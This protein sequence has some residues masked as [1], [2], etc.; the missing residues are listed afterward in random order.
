MNWVF[1]LRVKLLLP[2]L[3]G[4]IAL[5]VGLHF[6]LLPLL[7][8][9]ERQEFELHQYQL[10]HAVEP[11]AVHHLLSAGQDGLHTAMEEQKALYPEE[12]CGLSLFD[13]ND[14]KLYPPDLLKEECSGEH[15]IE[16]QQPVDLDGQSLGRLTLSV[17]WSHQ[18]EKLESELFQLESVILVL[19]L[20]VAVAGFV[21]QNFLIRLPLIRLQRAADKLSA[22]NFWSPLPRAGQDEMG[23]LTKAFERMRLEL[24]QT[25]ADIQDA[26][27]TSQ[28]NEARHLAVINTMADGLITVDDRGIVEGFNPAAEHI[29]GYT[30]DEVL[31]RNVAMLLPQPDAGDH[32]DFIAR[33]RE[34]AESNSSVHVRE[35]TGQHKNGDR[36]NLEVN[37]KE[38]KLS[39]GKIFSV[40]LRD[41]SE[42]RADEEALR[43]AASAFEVQ[44]GIVITDKGAR[45]LRVNRAFSKITGYREDEVVGK[46]PRLLQSGTHNRAF[47]K[48]FWKTL[49]DSGEWSGELLNQ[50]K[51]GEH[52]PQRTRISA[53]KN[54]QGEVTHYV[55][56]F[57]DVTERKIQ[58]GEIDRQA[59]EEEALGEML[60][61]SL[62]FT[63]MEN[64]LQQVLE[65]LFATVAMCQLLPQG[66]V[67]LTETSGAETPLKLVA[68]HGLFPE[69]EKACAVVPYGHCLCGR[70]AS[71]REIQFASS[72]DERHDTRFPGMGL[73]CHYNIP[74]ILGDDVLGVLMFYLPHGY[75]QQSGELEFL[76][77]VA[78]VLSLG[79][80]SRNNKKELEDAIDAAEVAARAKSDFLATMSHEI[81]TPMNGVLGM[82]QLLSDTRLN[83]EQREYMTTIQ[84][85]GEALL[86]II[87]DILDFSKMEADKMALELIPFDLEQTTF[88][89]TQLLGV[90]SREKGLELV[91]D[92]GKDC[93]RHL[94]GDAGRI[95]QILLNL[96][97]NAIKFT[98]EGHILL[99]VVCEAM[100]SD[101]ARL[102]IS[103][104]DT[105]IGISLEVQERLFAAFSQADGS[106][107]RRFGGTGLG[108]AISK[109]LVGM[110]G[111][112]IGV[113]SEVGSGAT[114]WIRLELPLS[115]VPEPLPQAS[116]S[117]VRALVV[118]DNKVKRRL[119]SRQL[120]GFGVTADI[121][122]NAKQALEML[123]E[124]LVAESY[125][126]MILDYQMPDMDGKELGQLIRQNPLFDSISL[127]M[128]SSGGKRGDARKFEE[129]GFA[130]YLS[131]PVQVDTL[132]GV[133]EGVVA[134]KQ[135]GDSR[136]MLTRY[137]VTSQ[138]RDK[139]ETGSFSG[140]VLLAED[141][142]TNQKV[143]VGMLEKLGLSVT[144]A[145]NGLEVLDRLAE[146]DFNLIL[147]DC[148][149]PE[150]DGFQATRA[151]R[152]GDRLPEIPIV[153]LTANVMVSDQQ[154]CRD[155]GMD[156]FLGKPFTR[157]EMESTLSCWLNGGESYSEHSEEPSPAV[158]SEENVVSAQAVDSATFL[159]MSEAIGE[160]AM[161]AL[162]PAFLTSSR[163]HIE[164]LPK[165]SEEGV[166]EEVVRIA[167]SLKSSCASL[168]AMVLSAM[169]K[170][171]EAQAREGMGAAEL[172]SAVSAMSQEFKRV[173]QE[174]GELWPLS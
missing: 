81:R 52:Y 158:S 45:I 42:Q 103:I 40:I 113:D 35:V 146:T 93:P 129:A 122:E 68:S 155:A 36:L 22:G 11:I 163:E 24:E 4:I 38:I 46:N 107:T 138:N 59:T 95:R 154:L 67:F 62:E 94:V 6:Y 130:A 32:D 10:L 61:L 140:K 1:G 115:S 23:S 37:L 101:C 99:Q 47:Y 167:H 78:D 164:R 152:S 118:D 147:M 54:K 76:H 91:F 13:E 8:I 18:L 111:G 102:R 55:G 165:A 70:A 69:L 108:L 134:V 119:L 148:Q 17:D 80:S 83:E 73:Q 156:S 100:D 116:L 39:E 89:V 50:R 74:I 34:I 21:W 157:V 51:S 162:V 7:V 170:K 9:E 171:L 12:W 49:A 20:F 90:K 144:V 123:R 105:G 14:S 110:M 28:S 168:G 159:A 16:I 29:F 41:V 66:G 82:S 72:D 26:L 124:S 57:L 172:E 63:S 133:L 3:L 5:F 114:F 15:F 33:H 96:M 143:A 139:S 141:D 56:S 2:I 149:M 128:L 64:Y 169:A 173:E 79:I 88:D 44:E 19:S 142:I 150:M 75:E 84:R 43:I 166:Q 109:R 120:V 121:A 25:H 106:T 31:G 58:Q 126:L 98:S 85:S 87:D 160:E 48:A 86:V 131:K 97:G 27:Y 127:V 125:Q 132:K 71:E 60:V 117:G 104:Q 137:Q 53:V 112:E 136:G 65:K 77:R 92:Y 135:Q 161:G 30:A 153:A 151:I 145:N 174:M